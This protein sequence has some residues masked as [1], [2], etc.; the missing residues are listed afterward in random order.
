MVWS[1][2]EVLDLVRDVNLASGVMECCRHELPANKHGLSVVF[3][4]CV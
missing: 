2:R 3:C 1:E 4:V